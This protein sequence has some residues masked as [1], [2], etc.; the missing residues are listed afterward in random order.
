MRLP[1]AYAFALSQ[2]W[3]A[4][5]EPPW[6]LRAV[7]AL[8]QD[9]GE[10]VVDEHG[11]DYLAR[12]T[13]WRNARLRLYLHLL[14]QDDHGRHRHLHPW[15]FLTIPLLHGY[16]EARQK[17]V[18]RVRPF[19]PRFRPRWVF[20]RVSGIRP[21]RPAITLV[22]AFV[23]DRAETSW[24]FEVER[25]LVPSQAYGQLGHKEFFSC[26]CGVRG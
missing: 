15:H 12:F 17:S 5:P 25:R 13:L 26:Y 23:A 19:W 9:R 6:W 7:F 22:T 1:S 16:D 10:V 11:R 2:G 24:G 3:L 4:D 21:G 20:H 18:N 8:A 14:L